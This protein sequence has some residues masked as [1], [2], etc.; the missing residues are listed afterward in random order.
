MSGESERKTEAL[1]SKPSLF[2]EYGFLV[3][4]LG[5]VGEKAN[6]LLLILALTS[7]LLDQVISIIVKGGSSGGKSYLV[8]RCL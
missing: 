7:R 3:E 4:R 5:V 8:K 1:L 6:A 2:S